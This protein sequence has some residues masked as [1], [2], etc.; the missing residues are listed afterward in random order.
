MFV[1]SYALP[2][3]TLILYSEFS[4]PQH[5]AITTA[6]LRYTLNNT[7]LDLDLK[8]TR[9]AND[10]DNRPSPATYPVQN[11]GRCCEVRTG[12]AAGLVSS[13]PSFLSSIASSPMLRLMKNPKFVF[14]AVFLG[15]QVHLLNPP[16]VSSGHV[17][18]REIGQDTEEQTQEA[19]EVIN[20]EERLQEELEKGIDQIQAK[21]AEQLSKYQEEF[22]VMF[23]KLKQAEENLIQQTQIYQEELSQY[24][25]EKIN[26][27]TKIRDDVDKLLKQAQTDT[28][29]ISKILMK[30]SM[31][32]EEIEKALKQIQNNEKTT[33]ETLIKVQ[34]DAKTISKI[35]TQVLMNEEEIEKALKQIQSNEKERGLCRIVPKG[36]KAGVEPA[37]LS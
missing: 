2:A 25:N 18:G 29:T 11:G 30:V 24:K 17:G 16:T 23:S 1:N 27:I 10:N 4:L 34:A 31:N 6:G 12:F 5:G 8:R 7:P 15:F 22:N 33:S 13:S 20:H 26:E 35:L 32:E 9:P 3:T 21:T 36:K 19:V 37:F 28:K 14:A